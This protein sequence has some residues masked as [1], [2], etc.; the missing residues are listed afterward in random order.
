MP[1]AQTE[2]MSRALWQAIL[3]SSVTSEFE[4]KI[5]RAFRRYHIQGDATLLF[6]DDEGPCKR[7]FRL[8][9]VSLEGIMGTTTT[10][11]PSGVACRIR[12][13]IDD[14]AL[15]LTGRVVHCT[16]SLSGC[17]VGIHLTFPED[18]AGQ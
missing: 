18:A 3:N 11:V 13:P 15:E 14:Q 5:R 12:M 8:I 17:K 4:P 6:D 9:N 1:D 7:V 2:P 16:G 10:P